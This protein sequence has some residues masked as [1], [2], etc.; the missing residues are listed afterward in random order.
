MQYMQPCIY[1]FFNK[2]V[3]LVFTVALSRARWG[4]MS[5]L[6]RAMPWAVEA[7]GLSARTKHIYYSQ[8]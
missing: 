4:V 6:L 1:N 8:S 5:R 3:P 7:I 2:K